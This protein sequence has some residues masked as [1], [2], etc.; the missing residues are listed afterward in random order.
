MNSLSS[1]FDLIISLCIQIV[2]NI[3]IFDCIVFNYMLYLILIGGNIL[4]E[5]LKE[6]RKSL[7]LSQRAF[8]QKLGMKQ[9]TYASFETGERVLKEAYIKLICQT[10]NVNENWLK[11][12]VGS[13]FTEKPNNNLTELLEIYDTLTPE[14]QKYLL[15]QIKELQS[16]Q[17]A[18]IEKKK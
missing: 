7:R 16:I 4:K 15:M 11:L 12:G 8:C 17:N 6:L 3:Y 13:V 18:E 2:K 1:L 5:R 14:L 10:Y 9:S